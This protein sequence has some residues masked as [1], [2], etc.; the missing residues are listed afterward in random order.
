[1][2]AKN[3]AAKAAAASPQRDTFAQGD[4]VIVAGAGRDWT[5]KVSARRLPDGRQSIHPQYDDTT[6]FVTFDETGISM[7][8]AESHVSKRTR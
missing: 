3:A 7:P 2:P 8:V 6:I 4:K 1:M 5:G